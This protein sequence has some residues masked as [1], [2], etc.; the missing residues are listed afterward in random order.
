ML[1]FNLYSKYY[2]ELPLKRKIKSAKKLTKLAST[3]YINSK[4][5]IYMYLLLFIIRLHKLFLNFLYRN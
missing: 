1:L 3:A 5:I 2:Q 4:L